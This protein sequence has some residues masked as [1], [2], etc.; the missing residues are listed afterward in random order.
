MRTKGQRRLAIP[1]LL[2]EEPPILPTPSE[3]QSSHGQ[4]YSSGSTREAV[5]KARVILGSA[6]NDSNLKPMLSQLTRDGEQLDESERQQLQEVASLLQEGDE[7]GEAG[8]APF[9]ADGHFELTA[10][11]DKMFL[12]LAVRP[13]IA[14]G[15]AVQSDQV[16]QWLRDQGVNRGVDVRAIQQAVKQAAGGEEVQDVVVARGR[17]PKAG[18]D[19]RVE[20]F[21]RTAG[22]GEPEL[23]TDRTIERSSENPLFCREGD[24]LV[25]YHPPQPGEAGHDAWGHPIEAP[26]PLDAEVTAGKHVQVDESGQK[27]LAEVSGV[28][29]FNGPQV[30]VRKALI[31]N[32]D[33]TGRSEAVDFDGEVHAKAGV[34]SGGQIKATGN[35]IVEGT[36]EAAEI[37]ST[38]GDVVLRSG[39]AGRHRAV[40]RAANDI[41]ARFAENANLLAGQDIRIQ[42]GALHSRLI[43]GRTVEADQ[44][45]GHITGGAVMAGELIRAK[46][47]G[48]RGGVQTEATVGISKK[49]MDMLG[50]IDELSARVQQRKDN[51]VELA[52][53][54]QRAVGDPRKLKATERQTYARLRE[55]QLVCD[56]HLRQLG[57][58]R[59]ELLSQSTEIGQGEIKV[60]LS[61]MPKVQLTIGSA[62]LEPD[63]D[64]G[65]IT[66]YYDDK[67][68]KIV[69]SRKS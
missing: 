57:Q 13:A 29:I 26:E 9:Q 2:C 23:L 59:D 49:T 60:L 63:A 22:D 19:G 48:G 65:P 8:E 41:I 64:R 14:E 55:L 61:I 44:G 16:V 6:L 51:A 56:V 34:R 58:R 47:L 31:L 35:I 17:E 27:Y 18:T 11:E 36:V 68:E 38:Q 1:S 66:F 69:N 15:E 28:V 40:I 4:E 53:Q 21:A 5:S 32:K 7:E 45:K 67:S 25:R 20:R 39:V 54:M 50:R 43:A 37:Q 33:V 46:Q 12:T 42:V 10:S 24:V 52:D 30:E 3:A 62:T